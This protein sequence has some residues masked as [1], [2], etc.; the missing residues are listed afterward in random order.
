MFEQVNPP[1]QKKTVNSHTFLTQFQT[2]SINGED[3]FIGP[4]HGVDKCGGIVIIET[5]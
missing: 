2:E 1:V 3:S 5:S 4:Y